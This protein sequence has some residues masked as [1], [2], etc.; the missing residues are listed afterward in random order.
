MP[1]AS[2]SS[3]VVVQIKLGAEKVESQS[4]KKA[5]AEEEQ[6]GVKWSIDE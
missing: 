3:Q 6:K 2:T 4:E 1:S 5:K